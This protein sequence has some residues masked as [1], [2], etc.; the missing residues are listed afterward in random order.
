MRKLLRAD[1]F[2]LRRSRV[3]WL[4]MAAAFAVSVLFLLRLGG[5]QEGVTTLDS[6][7]LQVFP[8]LPILHAAFVG[9]FLG[10]EYQDGTLRNKLIVGHSRGEVYGAYLLAGMAGC[11]AILLAWAASAAV[12]VIKFGWFTAPAGTLLLHA[13]VILLL[14]AAVAAIMTL[15]CMLV[16]NRA[17][18]AVFAI[19]LALAILILGSSLYNALCE[20]EMAAAAVM[21]QNGFEVG[22]PTPN[23][24]YIS[25]ALR[26]VYQFAV[27]ALPSGQAIL[28]ANQELTHPGLSLAASA[29]LTALASAAGILAFR[30]KDLK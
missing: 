17:I 26:T 8:F 19:L 11:F 7:F 1:L 10:M 28:L 13:A 2:C 14:T 24:S 30:R 12:G 18:S 25:G 3:L 4:C 6:V 21:T 5:D 27:N 22:E 9:L 16:P 15:L 23:P 20:P 29:G